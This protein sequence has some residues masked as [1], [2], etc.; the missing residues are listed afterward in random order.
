MPR[1]FGLDDSGFT[2]PQVGV[3]GTSNR[4]T[5]CN[6]GLDALRRAAADHLSE[7]G[8][9]FDTI[10]RHPDA[11]VSICRIRRSR[12]GRHSPAPEPPAGVAA[13]IREL[14]YCTGNHG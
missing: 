4:V 11:R 10:A 9:E 8:V 6:A 12:A 2:K 1:D 14:P 7:G 13:I 3:C 5:P